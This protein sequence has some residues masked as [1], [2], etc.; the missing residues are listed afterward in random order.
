MG[1]TKVLKKE[2]EGERVGLDVKLKCEEKRRVG[3]V[4]WN[5]WIPRFPSSGS[6]THMHQTST[7]VVR[8]LGISPYCYIYTKYEG[9]EAVCFGCG[10]GWG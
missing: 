2:R 8:E 9:P 3:F 10:G 7:S 1:L 6:G 5:V 4:S